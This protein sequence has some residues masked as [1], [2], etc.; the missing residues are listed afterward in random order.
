MFN[1][2]ETYEGLSCITRIFKVI[3]FILLFG[4][5]ST[6]L[7]LIFKVCEGCVDCGW[8]MPCSGQASWLDDGWL[9]AA[10]GFLTVAGENDPMDVVSPVGRR[11]G[12]GSQIRTWQLWM[13]WRVQAP[14]TP[15]PCWPSASMEG[16]GTVRVR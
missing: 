15:R 9:A 8:V 16:W 10:W 11:V 14:P 6:P 12:W 5:R 7:A 4:V 3:L 13:T 2:T 1:E